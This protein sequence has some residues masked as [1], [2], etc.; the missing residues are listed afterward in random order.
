LCGASW[1][2]LGK[3]LEVRGM[4]IITIPMKGITGN[5]IYE[6]NKNENE[7]YF[8]KVSVTGNEFKELEFEISEYKEIIFKCGDEFI[9][10]EFSQGFSS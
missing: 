2:N 1:T 7:N 9:I 3:T 5:R 10:Y 8:I 4:R 6:I